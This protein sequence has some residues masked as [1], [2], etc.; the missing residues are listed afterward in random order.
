MKDKILPNQMA[1]PMVAQDDILWSADGMD[2][3]T[4]IATALMQAVMTR[5]SHQTDS[6]E[7]AVRCAD[8]LIAELN[9]ERNHDTRETT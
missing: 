6:A 1:F 7:Y 8:A 5:G 3:R 4:Y 9:K 2:L